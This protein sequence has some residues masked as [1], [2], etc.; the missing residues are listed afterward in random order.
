MADNNLTIDLKHIIKIFYKNR[1]PFLKSIILN[2]V[3]VILISFIIKPRYIST[4][5]LMPN[6]STNISELASTAALFGIGNPNSGDKESFNT[7]DIIE[8]LIKSKSFSDM[9]LDKAIIVEG[10]ENK[11]IDLFYEKDDEFSNQDF[12]NKISN[13]IYIKKDPETGIYTINFHY[14][15]PYLSYQ[16][17]NMILETLLELRQNILLS[18]TNEEKLFIE[19]KMEYLNS[20]MISL[21]EEL[22]FFVNENLNFNSSPVLEI[23]YSRI[24]SNLD[25]TSNLYYSYQQKLEELYLEEKSTLSGLIVIDKPHIA[26]R[27]AFPSISFYLVFLLFSIIF[28]NF[29]ILIYKKY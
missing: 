15:D 9:L 5:V 16:I 6:Q 21:E 14:N 19:K 18:L 17:C 4:F 8:E 2:L 22:I 11:I 12:R 29:P 3:F 10:S 28:I 1:L 20:A 23:K 24:K 13:F 26:D 27:P 7:P 25:L